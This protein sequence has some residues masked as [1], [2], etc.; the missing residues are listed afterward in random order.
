MSRPFSYNDE[1][2]TVIGNILFVHIKITKN[3]SAG[4]NVI[5]IPM[6]IFNHLAHYTNTLHTVLMRLRV[7]E[8]TVITCGMRELNGRYYIVTSMN[9]DA[10][11]SSYLNGYYLLKDI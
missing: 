6:E 2:F 7:A 1:N 9:I 3:I 11:L 4:G 5:E 8:S 10:T